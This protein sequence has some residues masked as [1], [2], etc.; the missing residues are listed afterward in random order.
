[1]YTR[2]FPAPA[3]YDPPC[4]SRNTCIAFDELP[5]ENWS[6]AGHNQGLSQRFLLG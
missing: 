1:M 4:L 6:I 3:C 2:L 5:D